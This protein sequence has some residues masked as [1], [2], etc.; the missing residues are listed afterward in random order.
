MCFLLASLK[1]NATTYPFVAFVALQPRSGSRTSTSPP[2]PTLTIL[3][4][5]QGPS[6]PNSPSIPSSTLGPTSARALCDHLTNQLLPRVT[7]YL[8]RLKSTQRERDF[9]RKL[10]EEQDAA[11]ELA[12]QRD[13]ERIQAKIA[14]EKEARRAAERAEREKQEMEAAKTRELNERKAR[15]TTRIDWYRYAR[16]CLLPPESAP[17]PGVVRIGIR[18]VDG[19]RLI[20]H[21]KVTDTLTALYVFVAIQSIPSAFDSSSDPDHPPEGYLAEEAGIKEEDWSIKLVSAYP[22]VEIPWKAGTSLQEV[23]A[24]KGGGQLVVEATASSTTDDGYDTEEE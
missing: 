1:L 10:R 4:R 12:A 11:F 20:R 5:H 14:A 16:R 18:M 24:L 3:S 23:D 19:R 2:L 7:P 15:E 17:G 8:G 6:A 22:R 21:F 13:H 9:E